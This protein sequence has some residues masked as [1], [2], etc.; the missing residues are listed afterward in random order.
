MLIEQFHISKHM[1]VKE[2]FPVETPS[3]ETFIGWVEKTSVEEALK[4]L[5]PW[6]TFEYFHATWSKYAVTTREEWLAWH[7]ENQKKAVK[8]TRARADAAVDAFLYA[9][10]IQRK[11][12]KI[13]H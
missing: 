8:D 12:S 4:K 5:E 3:L 9:E 11:L 1:D 10:K 6:S 7:Q 2:L 13:L